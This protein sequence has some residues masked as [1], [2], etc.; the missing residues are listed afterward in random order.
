M[1]NFGVF[2]GMMACR[3]TQRLAENDSKPQN[4]TS[5]VAPRQLLLKEK[6]IVTARIASTLGEVASALYAEDGGGKFHRDE[7]FE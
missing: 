2:G 3:P 7:D 1:R 5:S 6:P 4:F